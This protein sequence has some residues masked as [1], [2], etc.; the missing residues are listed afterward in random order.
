MRPSQSD[1][2]W[3]FTDPKNIAVFTVADVMNCVKPILYVSHDADDGSWQFMPG[4]R[5]SVREA[6]ILA[7][8]EIVDQDPTTKQLADLPEGWIAERDSLD[9]PWR[10]FKRSRHDE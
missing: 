4:G 5:V 1:S 8:H 7:L 9:S 6:K 3:P 2:D 10:R